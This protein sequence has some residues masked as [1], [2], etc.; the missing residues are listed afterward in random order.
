VDVKLSVNKCY[1]DEIITILEIPNVNLRRELRLVGYTFISK[2]IENC[3]NINI[4]FFLLFVQLQ[5]K[6]ILR[7]HKQPSQ[8][9][10]ALFD[11]TAKEIV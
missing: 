5:S 2:M 8:A 10:F 11:T 7:L 1:S 6:D 4:Y 3:E 9:L